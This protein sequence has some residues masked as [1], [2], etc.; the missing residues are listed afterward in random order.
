MPFKRFNARSITKKSDHIPICSGLFRQR[1][2][3]PKFENMAPPMVDIVSELNPLQPKPRTQ[4]QSDT[5]DVAVAVH[6][7]GVSLMDEGKI[8]RA[9]ACFEQVLSLS[10]GILRGNK[11]ASRRHNDSRQYLDVRNFACSCAL[12]SFRL[13][14][15][16]YHA[17]KV[18]NTGFVDWTA[19]QLK[20]PTLFPCVDSFSLIS[21]VAT[22]NL[23]LCHHFRGLIKSTPIDL[24]KSVRMYE[25]AH[26]LL[27]QQ[28]ERHEDLWMLLTIVNNLSRALRRI[29]DKRRASLCCSRVLAILVYVC[30][31]EDLEMQ[32]AIYDK[33]L[34]NVCHLILGRTQTAAAA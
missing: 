26:A 18:D 13:Q 17:S 7:R 28:S 31:H 16:D 6:N 19:L 15:L 3:L 8:G 21:F 20:D 1:H 29:G 27:S 22:Y 25:L 10:R 24:K 34:S 4:T 33:Y 32:P 2:F 23:A 9:V 30:N 14:F 5:L 11:S 12:S